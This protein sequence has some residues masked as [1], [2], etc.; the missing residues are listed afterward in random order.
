VPLYLIRHTRVA[1]PPGLCYGHLDVA[2]ADTFTNEA[3]QV[4]AALPAVLPPVWSSPSLRCRQLAETLAPSVQLDAR[5]K[6]LSFGD[7]E[8]QTWSELDSPEARHWGNHWQTARPPGGET[9]TELVERVD[10]FL[11]ELPAGD[12]VIVAHAGSI[13]VLLH[14]LTGLSLEA[15]FQR[16]IGYGEVIPVAR[17]AEI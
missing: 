17:P 9:L 1:A 10:T 12:Q 14:W 15:A 3:Q 16:P 13:R 5:L 4:R 7:W 6:E 2:L 11:Q 8:G